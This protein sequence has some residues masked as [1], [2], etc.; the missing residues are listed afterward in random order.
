VTGPFETRALALLD[1]GRNLDLAVE[2]YKLA[3]PALEQ[4]VRAWRA[5]VAEATAVDALT[6]APASDNGKGSEEA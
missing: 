4:A 2:R 6:A 5:A 1:A 3:R